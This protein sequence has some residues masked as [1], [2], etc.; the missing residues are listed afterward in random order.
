LGRE[1]YVPPRGQVGRLNHDARLVIEGA[2]RR[3]SEADYLG[4]GHPTAQLAHRFGDVGDDHSGRSIRASGRRGA[5]QNARLGRNGGDAKLGS[6]EVDRYR[7]GLA[8][9]QAAL[10]GRQFRSIASTPGVIPGSR[11]DEESVGR[12]NGFRSAG[13]D[14][15]EN[16]QNDVCL[17]LTSHCWSSPAQRR[18]GR[19]TWRSKWRSG[20]AARS[21]RRILAWSTDT[22]MSAPPS[23]V[24]TSASAC[25][26]T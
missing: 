17:N 4:I 10:Q 15:S 7:Y 1:R 25:R 3:H 11:S 14:T 8:C 12:T 18:W 20:S 21:S 5:V 22:W 16:A 23:L 2:R 6:P 13:N 19:A 24:S 26:I 9:R